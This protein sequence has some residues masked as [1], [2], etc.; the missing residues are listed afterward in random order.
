MEMPCFVDGWG[1]LVEL[2]MRS[3]C[4]M[5]EGRVLVC[6]S[7]KVPCFMDERGFEEGCPQNRVVF[8]GAVPER[9]RFWAREWVVSGRDGAAGDCVAMVQ[10]SWETCSN[11]AVLLLK[12]WCGVALLHGMRDFCRNGV[13]GVREGD[14]GFGWC[15]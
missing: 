6:L 8:E 5:D 3:A 15:A 4:F 11:G 7:M 9:M 2:S 10:E 1:I 13:W 14:V 12:W